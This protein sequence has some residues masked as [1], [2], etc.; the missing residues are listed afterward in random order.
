MLCY[1]NMFRFIME[2]KDL[3]T[4]ESLKALMVSNKDFLELFDIMVK[5]ARNVRK[6]KKGDSFNIYFLLHCYLS[7]SLNS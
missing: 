3:S 4:F 6:D 2:G 7:K 5:E 1:V